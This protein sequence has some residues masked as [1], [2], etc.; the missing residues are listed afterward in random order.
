MTNNIE[1]LSQYDN[2][3]IGSNNNLTQLLANVVKIGSD[4]SN[5]TFSI[6]QDISSSYNLVLPTRSGI[7]G[8]SLIYGANGQL[9]WGDSSVLK[10]VVSVYGNNLS[11]EKVPSG[12]M[13]STTYPSGYEASI[14]PLSA[15][16]KIFV[17]FK[18]N[19]KAALAADNQIDFYIDKRI[20]GLTVSTF[21]ETMFGPFLA[22]GGYVGQY[23]SN[24]VDEAS[25]TDQITYRLGFKVNGE[26]D[27]SNTLGILGYDQSYNNTIVLQ[28]F[29][30][31]GIYATSVWNKGSDNLGLYY[32]NGTI[33][34]GTDLNALN[35]T[36][37]ENVALKVHG[38][39]SAE[40]ADLTGNVTAT[41]FFGDVTG[42]VTGTVSSL[43]NH[44][45][46]NLSEGTN[47][48]FTSERVRTNISGGSGIDYNQ[49][50]GQFTLANDA[51]FNILTVNGTLN[52]D[53]ITGSNVNVSNDLTVSG[54][55]T[56]NGTQTIINSTTLD[57][58]DN[59][60]VVHAYGSQTTA[61]IIANVSGTPHEFVYNTVNNAW[62]TTGDLNIGGNVACNTIKVDTS[63]TLGGITATVSSGSLTVD[64]KNISYGV[65][66]ISNTATSITGLTMS[67]FAVNSQILILYTNTSGSNLTINKTITNAKTN[68][69][70]ALTVSTGTSVLICIA[71]IAGTNILTVSN[72]Y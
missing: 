59:K 6:P 16:T 64:A 61:G 31:S 55:L 7:S 58:S 23:I 52:S 40:N 63:N 11:S 29:E 69:S 49:S 34:A 19:Y 44:T 56:V 68:L 53:D 41:T 72:L 37:I 26:V 18:V 32:N 20:N 2:F 17:Q 30:G 70:S 35:S 54:N 22:A 50:T 42:N 36:N 4:I 27:I 39:L 51:T 62:G 71:N 46:T 1:L 21:T 43:S 3:T 65:T 8:K 45:T 12:E 13:N 67:N 15:N 25:S 28:E 60:I 14:T 57:I 24:L 10:Q 38:N 9:E 48:Y 5:V 47:L 33:H 66:S